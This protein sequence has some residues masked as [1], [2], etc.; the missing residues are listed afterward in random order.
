MAAFENAAVENFEDRILEHVQTFF[1]IH[2]KI[3]GEEQT[4]EVI[5]LGFARAE[6][7]G[8][9]TE[10]DTYLYIG[11]IFML[12]S[13]FDSDPQLPWAADIL[14]GENV[15]VDATR[16]ER[17]DEQ[18]MSYLNR[19]AGPDNE[20]LRAALSRLQ[21]LPLQTWS[22]PPTEDFRRYLH[23]QLFN[24]FP[25]KYQVISEPNLSELMEKG[26]KAAGHH[27]ISSERGIT[28]YMGLMVL[29]GAGFDR[30]PQ[31]PWATAILGDKSLADPDA[32]SDQLYQGAMAHLNRWLSHAETE[33]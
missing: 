9:M 17:L 14:G 16:V 5:R 23:M 22:R 2:F 11:L 27:G 28:I 19:V 29:L 32:K 3:L 15:R 31:Y 30:D 21:G 10:R 25:E 20:H 18:A 26:K 1:P 7:H 24:L 4:R 33:D 13:Y 6:R 12:G 8:I